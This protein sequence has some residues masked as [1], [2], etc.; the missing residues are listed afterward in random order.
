MTAAVTADLWETRLFSD[1]TTGAATTASTASEW[2]A[3]AASTGGPAPAVSARAAFQDML[4]GRA[5]LLDLRP[6]TDRAAEGEVAAHLGPLVVADPDRPWGVAAAG[7]ARA[8]AAVPDRQVVVLGRSA[9]A[10]LD[11]ESLS[12]LGHRRVA[13]IRGGFRAWHEAGLPTQR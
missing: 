5:V 4:H 3:G 8:L 10:L 11:A 6:A 9:E 2:A 12:Q 7:A 1:G 13:V